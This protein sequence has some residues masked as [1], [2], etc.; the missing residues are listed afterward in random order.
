[1]ITFKYKKEKNRQGSVIF[2]PVADVILEGTQ[3]SIEVPMYIDSGADLS[4]IPLSV[5]VALGFE[6][7]AEEIKQIKG[8]GGETIPYI[9]R[10]VKLILPGYKLPARIGWALIDDVPILLGRLDI[11]RK[12]KIIFDEAEKLVFFVPKF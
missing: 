11:F 10:N 6:E 5:G 3:N 7:K 9:V 2:R 8:I 4:L 12:F 1:M